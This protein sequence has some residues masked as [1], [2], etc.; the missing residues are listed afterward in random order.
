MV[1]KVD[2]ENN[3]EGVSVNKNTVA[4]L[5]VLLRPQASFETW[6]SLSQCR[7]G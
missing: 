7:H 3:G 2:D 6:G 4:D 1:G 5:D